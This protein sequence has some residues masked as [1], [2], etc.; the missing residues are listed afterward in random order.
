MN[1]T[2]QI[3]I[4]L[5]QCSTDELL[6]EIASRSCDGTRTDRFRIKLCE[7]LDESGLQFVEK[8]EPDQWWNSLSIEQ[9]E[10][11]SQI[12]IDN[13]KQ[14]QDWREIIKERS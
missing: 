14:M 6:N 12:R 1:Q 4:N 2:V 9:K 7:A 8:C 11:I 3:E 10:L 5:S 13:L